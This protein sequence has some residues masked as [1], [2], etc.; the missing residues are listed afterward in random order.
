VRYIIAQDRRRMDSLFRD[1][2]RE[3]FRLT[4]IDR[5]RSLRLQSQKLILPCALLVRAGLTLR[6][7]AFRLGKNLLDADRVDQTR[8]VVG[9]N[10]IQRANIILF[11]ALAQIFGG[12]KTR[13]AIGQVAARAIA[14]RNERLVR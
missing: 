12:D 1:Y 4:T 13:F 2:I 7:R 8:Y 6:R 3:A 9:K 14:K 11:Q 5:N 10:V